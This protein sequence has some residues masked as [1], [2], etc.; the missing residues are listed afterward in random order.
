MGWRSAVLIVIL[1]FGVLLSFMYVSSL[2]HVPPHD[3][4]LIYTEPK[5]TQLQAI[6]I[7]EQ[8]LEKKVQSFDEAYLHFYYY[9]FSSQKYEKDRDYQE[10]MQS[11][12]PGWSLSH[13][14]EK[15]EFLNLTLI[16]VHANGT[17]YQYN[18][19]SQEFEKT[20]NAPSVNCTPGLRGGEAARNRLVYEIGAIVKGADYGNDVH[21]IIDA[22]TGQV[23]LDT[24]DIEESRKR[25]P[26]NVR[27]YENASEALTIR[28]E[29]QVKLEKLRSY[30]SPPQLTI[31]GIADG[32]AANDT[33][34]KDVYFEPD[35]AR[36]VIGL[37]NM[38]AWI[39][40]DSVPHT[41]VSDTGYSN[42]YAGKF[43]SGMI[44]PSE[45]FQ[46]PF[47]DIGDYLY[48]CEIHPWM[49]GEVAIV[50]NFS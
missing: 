46:Y 37:S 31:I 35:Q 38:I 5:V 34:R 27:I 2:Y 43:D 45:I 40:K 49:K 13:V 29:E 44:G 26:P 11:I 7:V 25:F 3:P 22:E 32:A 23:V 12:H 47:I 16:F 33:N 1:T 20:C 48:H 4:S 17:H 14:K 24:I 9:N 18:R 10:Y 41:V 8:D 21:F 30:L 42:E 19:E 36:G 39:N 6:E 50:E 28:E 15:P